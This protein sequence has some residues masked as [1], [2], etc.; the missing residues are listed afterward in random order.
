MGQYLDEIAPRTPNFNPA[1]DVQQASKS[2]WVQYLT[3]MNSSA[4]DFADFVYQ[5]R[6]QAIAGVDEIVE[7]VIAKLEEKGVI[8]N[9]YSTWPVPSPQPSVKR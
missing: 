7:D 4:I 2:G 3:E 8:D 9:T 1:A 5:S 6:I